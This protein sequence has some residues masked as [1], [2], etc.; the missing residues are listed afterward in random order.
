[1]PVIER[2]VQIDAPVGRVYS[3]LADLPRHTEWAAHPLKLTAASA[4]PTATGSRFE[5]VG[6]MMGKDFHDEVTVTELKENS[7]ISFEVVS[8]NNLLRHRFTMRPSGS[9]T[10]LTKSME[11]L[12]AGFP[13][14][15]VAP[16]LALTGALA[17]GLAGDLARIKARVEQE[18]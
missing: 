3:Y 2:R 8:G 10:D 9:G 15:V 5:S 17:Q 4:G 1:M 16:V 12:K 13:F 6:H 7:L 14:A 11:A 18:K